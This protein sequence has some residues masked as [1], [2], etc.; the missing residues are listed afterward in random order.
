MMLFQP[1]TLWTGKQLFG[2]ILR[3]S[4]SCPVKANLRCK[5][6]NYSKNED[7]CTSD[8]CEFRRFAKMFVLVH[9][10]LLLFFANPVLGMA[11][12]KSRKRTHMRIRMKMVK[13]TKRTTR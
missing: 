9:V 8:S 2:L 6:K 11:G 3:P 4:R 12:A 7:L 5:G 1:M 10:S 13:T